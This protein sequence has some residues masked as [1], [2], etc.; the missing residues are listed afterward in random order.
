MHEIG[1]GEIWGGIQ[2]TDLEAQ[3]SAVRASLFSAACGG[4]KGGDIYYFS[5]CASDLITRI[6]IADV[7]GHGEPVSATSQW[8]YDSLQERMNSV[9]SHEVLADLNRRATGC[10]FQAMTTAAVAAFYRAAGEL[11]FSYAG[12]HP[13]LV[14]R[15]TEAHW[16]PAL[17]PE[18]IGASN[19]PLG[20][21]ADLPYEQST[22][23]LAAGDQLFLYTDGLVEARGPGGELFGN[24][25]LQTV[26]DALSGEA[27]DIKQ[28]VLNDLLGFVDGPMHHDDVTF[29]AVSI[30]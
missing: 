12:H 22:L 17:L 5:V 1:C 25:R 29:M 18:D 19:L 20:V 11:N 16:S 2:G 6:A 30:R 27:V 8:L 24:Q 4:G 9:D 14:R 10:G 26:L 13:V 28:G 7:A 3:T 23:G 15:R 21:D